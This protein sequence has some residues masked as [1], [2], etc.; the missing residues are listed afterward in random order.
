[1]PTVNSTMNSKVENEYSTISIFDFYKHYKSGNFIVDSLLQRNYVWSLK[2]RKKFLAG[3]LNSG[4][5]IGCIN[6]YRYRSGKTLNGKHVWSIIDGYQRGY[7]I[8]LYLSGEIEL[9]EKDV[10][11]AKNKGYFKD[12]DEETRVEFINV[13]I[14]VCY[15]VAPDNRA[16]LVTK[17]FIS[18]NQGLIL[19]NGELLKAVSFDLRCFPVELA[20]AICNEDRLTLAPNNDLL[21][22]CDKEGKKIKMGWAKNIVQIQNG[23]SEKNISKHEK[24]NYSQLMCSGRRYDTFARV[25]GMIVC[26]LTSGDIPSALESTF[27]QLEPILLYNEKINE[28]SQEIFDKVALVFSEFSKFQREVAKV[29]PEIKVLGNYNNK[30]L[31]SSKVELAYIF[32]YLCKKDGVWEN[33]D[34]NKFIKF[35]TMLTQYP[36]L[37]SLWSIKTPMFLGVKRGTEICPLFIQQAEK[38]INQAVSNKFELK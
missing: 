3:I 23:W 20:F 2:K 16:D 13:K 17:I 1:M 30:N 38:F 31:L 34:R 33:D 14:A 6:C 22:Q 25:L 8:Y 35:Y 19:N 7:T 36:R 5:P 9:S 37:Y 12:L 11:D 15:N 29:N 28:F 18:L 10:S 24:T 32:L 4:N 26:I 27:K 21:Q